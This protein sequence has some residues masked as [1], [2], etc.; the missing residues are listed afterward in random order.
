MVIGGWYCIISSVVHAL[1]RLVVAVQD[2]W[3]GGAVVKI[4]P[5]GK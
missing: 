1:S 5:E 2:C 4:A 3:R